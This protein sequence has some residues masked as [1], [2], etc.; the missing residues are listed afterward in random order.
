[1]IV[2]L[3][4]I[5]IATSPEHHSEIRVR[6]FKRSWSLKVISDILLIMMIFHFMY[7]PANFNSEENVGMKPLRLI[8]L[9]FRLIWKEKG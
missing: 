8:I 6:N 7:A 2:Y 9:F 4:Y 1:M 3:E 5:V